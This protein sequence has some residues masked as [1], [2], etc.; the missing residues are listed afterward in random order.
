MIRNTFL[1]LSFLALSGAAF[2]ATLNV[3]GSTGFNPDNGG[4]FNGEVNGVGYTLWCVDYLNAVSPPV[5]GVNV[6]VSTPTSLANIALTR[7][8]ITATA[9][10][11]NDNLGPNAGG[12]YDA[13]ARYLM[14]GW[15]ITQFNVG[16][17]SGDAFNVGNQDAI[18]SILSA[19]GQT[20]SPNHSAQLGARIAAA[21]NWY[22]SQS[23]GQLTSFGSSLRI[24]SDATIPSL[25]D[26]YN[27]GIQE[28][29]I[30]GVPEPG[31]YA[32]MGAGLAALGL[33]RR[34]KA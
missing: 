7:Y 27:G 30:V 8:G 1:T 13:L 17:G 34:R 12:P 26:R 20:V 9:N 19:D 24:V 5:A 23:T 4:S 11:A 15:L 32:L 14:A 21:E 18:W 31:T 3:G 33:L 29:M 16:L 28:F 6:N 25:R 10:F 22:N 2:A